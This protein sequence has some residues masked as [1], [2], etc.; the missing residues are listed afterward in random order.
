MTSPFPPATPTDSPCIRQCC[1]DE[2]NVCVGCGRTLEE[3]LNWHGMTAEEKDNARQR[4][5]AR[6]QA[7]RHPGLSGPG[8]P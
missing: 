8:R 6:C 5:H 3:I 4:A 7:R 1:L 2:A